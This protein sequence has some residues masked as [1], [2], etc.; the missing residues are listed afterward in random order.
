MLNVFQRGGVTNVVC[1]VTR[2]FG[3]ILLGAGGLTR[4]YS[5][6]ARDALCAAGYAVMGQWAV[7]SVPCTYAMLERVKLE[8]AAQDGTVD[9]TEYGADI[10]LT[11][12]LPAERVDALQERLTEL[13]AGSIAVTVDSAEFRPGPRQEL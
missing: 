11:V 6:G 4:A 12:S 13:S 10:R 9:D 2:Y 3:G 8:V 5:K 1:V 7:V